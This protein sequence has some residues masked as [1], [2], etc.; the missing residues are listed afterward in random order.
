MT[1]ADLKSDFKSSTFCRIAAAIGVICGFCFAF[2][3]VTLMF[4]AAALEVETSWRLWLSAT[5]EMAFP[6]FTVSAS[7]PFTGLTCFAN[8]QSVAVAPC[9]WA[10]NCQLVSAGL[11]SAVAPPEDAVLQGTDWV[12]TSNFTVDC[13]AIDDN[14]TD[15][16]IHVGERT[17]FSLGKRLGDRIGTQAP[18]GSWSWISATREIIT[19]DGGDDLT[20]W[21]TTHQFPVSSTQPVT[22]ITL[23]VSDFITRQLAA[24]DPYTGFMALSDIGGLSFVLYTLWLGSMLLVSLVLP[25]DT[26]SIS[27]GRVDGSTAAERSPLLSSSASSGTTAVRRTPAAADDDN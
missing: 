9:S 6:N 11:L 7:T 17:L 8:K 13:I 14:T 25:N 12:A 1:L 15:L 20:V 27:V 21:H 16:T 3:A 19:V 10:K 5:D 24:E 18:A 23:I 2:G 26:K 4:R 22:R